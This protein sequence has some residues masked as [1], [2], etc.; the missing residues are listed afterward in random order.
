[1]KKINANTLFEDVEITDYPYI[2][3]GK[4]P[5]NTHKKI[6]TDEEIERIIGG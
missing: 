5:L 2:G 3:I 4:K 1:M 6:L